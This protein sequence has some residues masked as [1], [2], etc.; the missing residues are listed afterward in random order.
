MENTHAESDVVILSLK[1][2]PRSLSRF[3]LRRLFVILALLSALEGTAQVLETKP[4]NLLATRIDASGPRAGDIQALESIKLDSLTTE[5]LASYLDFESGE[6]LAFE[7]LA[8]PRRVAA[9]KPNVQIILEIDGPTILQSTAAKQ[10][11]I[12]VLVI[13]L[14]DSDAVVEHSAEV[15]T[16]D[17]ESLGET[18]WQRGLKYSTFIP[19]APGKYSLRIVLRNGQT[20]ASAVRS[21]PLDVPAFESL[22]GTFIQPPFFSRQRRSDSWLPVHGTSRE[23]LPQRTLNKLPIPSARPVLVAG[24]RAKGHIVGYKLP[25]RGLQGRIRLSKQGRMVTGAALGVGA[26]HEYNSASFEAV[27]FGFETPKVLPGDYELLVELSTGVVSSRIPVVILQEGSRDRGL[28]WTDLRSRLT[29]ALRDSESGEP[30][31]P[32][33]SES[34][35]EPK[36]IVARQ[37]EELTTQYKHAIARVGQSLEAKTLLLN[38]E[39]SV[40][41]N[42]SLELLQTAEFEVVELLAKKDVESL[43]PVLVLHSDMYLVYRDRKL[44]SLAS[45][46]RTLA[47]YLADLYA[48]Y[49]KSQGSRIVA[50]RALT[51]LAGHLQESNLPSNSRRLYRRALEYDPQNEAAVLGLATSYERHA[52]YSQAVR[53]LEEL[54]EGHPESGE[55]LLRLSINLDRLGLEGRAIEL[56]DRIL[57]LDVADWV[58]SLAF[59]NQARRLIRQNN[60]EAATLLLERAHKEVS[61]HQGLSYLLAHAYDLQRQPLRAL[62]VIEKVTPETFQGESARKNYDSWPKASLEIVRRELSAAATVRQGLVA[63]TL[64]PESG[65]GQ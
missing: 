14:S 39:S 54:V 30:T 3:K 61:D 5:R 62:E 1:F 22:D 4:D 63:K 32:L 23:E 60:Y 64:Q 33:E 41:L 13:V 58:R 24:R 65:A 11:Q 55:A 21:L 15:F 19:L 43:L 45:I 53:L 6:E 59:Q 25:D 49:G 56:T 8:L 35:A 12:E 17:P 10:S 50:A 16:V 34:P 44:F 46:A 38:L 36:D 18:I 26:R 20:T 37:I 7:A 2:T 9:G 29:P 40:L 51:S 28:L 47:E 48:H 42:G 27:S 52:E 57:E 31:P